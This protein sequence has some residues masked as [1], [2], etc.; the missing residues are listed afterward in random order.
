MLIRSEMQLIV[1]T[2]WRLL[3]IDF[4]GKKEEEE[5]GVTTT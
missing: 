2:Q 5:E 3:C 4:Q 1:T